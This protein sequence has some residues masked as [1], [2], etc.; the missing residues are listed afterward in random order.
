M[1]DMDVWLGDGR[2]LAFTISGPAD[3]YPVFYLH[4][5]PGSRLEPVLPDPASQVG[6]IC[7]IAP[8]RPGYGGSSPSPQYNL[9]NHAADIAALADHLGINRFSLFGFSG[10][11]VFA[12]ATAA[13][14]GSRVEHVVLV[15]TPASPLLE[16]PLEGTSELNRGAWQQALDDPAAL[17]AML[18]PLVED[19]ETLLKAMLDGVSDGDRE[20][21]TSPEYLDLYRND[22]AAAVNQG[23]DHAA[24]AVARDIALTV[25]PWPFDVKAL[26]QRVHVLHGKDDGLLSPVHAQALAAAIPGSRLEIVPGCGHYAAVYGPIAAGL[27]RRTLPQG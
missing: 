21:L 17:P 11:G 15:G 22:M 24:A 12:M 13:E 25:L 8:D 14:L 4:G 18:A 3:G 26:G 5:V 9:V 27:W 6:R 1:N 20:L 10:G 19:G 16:D 2:R 7:I 23:A